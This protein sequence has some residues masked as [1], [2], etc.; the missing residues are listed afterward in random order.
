MRTRSPVTIEHIYI[1]IPFCLKKCGYCSF[2]SESYS[3]EKTR[4]Y[5]SCLLKEIEF[6]QND[7]ILKPRTIYFGGG[8][9]SL[10][11]SEDLNNIITSFDLSSVE[12]ITIEVNPV[13]VTH[14]MARGLFDA[15]INRVSLGIQSFRD[16]ELKLLGRLHNQKEVYHAWEILQQSGIKN[17]SLDLIYGLPFQ[18][19]NDLEY[20]VKEALKLAPQH[21]SIYCL[22]LDEDVPMYSF[23]SEL[24]SAEDTA[25]F[26]NFICQELTKS[27]FQHYEISN[28]A[29]P[30]FHS[31]HNDAYWSDKF[32]VGLGASASGYLI[33]Q[34]GNFH[35]LR[36]TNK[37]NLQEYYK[38]LDNRIIAPSPIYLTSE[39]HQKEYIF[40]GL[41]RTAGLN[42]KQ[43]SS[44]FGEDFAEKYQKIIKKYQAMDLLETDS[45]FV[46]LK[47]DAYFIS[48]E[49]FSEFI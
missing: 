26:Y 42:L 41:R 23:K 44:T 8:T 36:Y 9:P 3:T 32:Y 39:D 6:F 48:N 11:N 29:R 28:F 45:G 27:R 17:L 22:S 4:E 18:V 47:P 25:D 31:R 30:G 33:E 1:H 10:L 15:G 46:K 12:E 34:S 43:F 21:I 40:L 13:T 2:Y 24:P 7:H 19:M 49:I 14:Q 35:R 20:S 38:D 37:S 16:N 5:V